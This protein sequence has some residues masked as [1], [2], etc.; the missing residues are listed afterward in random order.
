MTLSHGHERPVMRTA[1]PAGDEMRKSERLQ[2]L[3][4][5]REAALTTDD[6]DRII[7]SDV[8]AGQEVK[9]LSRRRGGD[10]ISLLAEH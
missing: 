8:T 7:F 4:D 3:T 10:I 2:G 6:A 1:H 9:S 5:G